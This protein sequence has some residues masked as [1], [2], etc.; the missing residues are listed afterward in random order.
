MSELADLL[1]GSSWK[2]LLL[3]LFVFGTAPGLV[4]RFLV[5]AYPKGHPRRRELVAQ[6]YTIPRGMR[7]LWVAEQ[8]EVALFEGVPHRW[9]ARRMSLNRRLVG[10]WGSLVASVVAYGVAKF[11]GA[12]DLVSFLI[13]LAGGWVGLILLFPSRIGRDRR[14]PQDQAYNR[15]K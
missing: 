1:L 4:L 13:P 12:P 14:S 6:L 8:V 3:V 2:T 7:P 5:L 11:A 9:R 15:R 10:F